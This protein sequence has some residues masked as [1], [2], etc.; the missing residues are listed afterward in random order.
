MKNLLEFLIF[1]PALMLTILKQPIAGACKDHI[2]VHEVV[3]SQG[4]DNLTSIWKLQG[5]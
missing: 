5:N 3:L 1:Q 4:I 2:C